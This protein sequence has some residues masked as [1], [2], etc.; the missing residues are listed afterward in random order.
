MTTTRKLSVVRRRLMLAV[1]ALG[2]IVAVIPPAGAAAAPIPFQIQP[3]S[4]GNPNGSFDVPPIHCG[5]E[6]GPNGG[7]LTITGML[8]GRW[9][10]LPEAQV[11]WV[12]LTTMATGAARMSNG[13]HGIPAEATLRTGAGQVVVKIDALSGIMTPGVATVWVR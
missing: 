6:T 2:V 5:F 13:L 12:N 4:F 7:E 1:A 8:R 10:C 3:A 11:S 9:G